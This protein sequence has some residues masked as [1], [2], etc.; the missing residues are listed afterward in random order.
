MPELEELMRRLYLLALLCCTA[1]GTTG[2]AP[3]NTGPRE[4]TVSNGATD[5]RIT[6]EDYT[7]GTEFAT[8]RDRVW[9][10]LL[11]VHEELGIPL[12]NADPRAGTLSYF[13]QVYDH[14]IA[15][16]PASMYVDCG[17]GSTGPR[18][19]SYRIRLIINEAVIQPLGNEK[20]SLHTT[21]QVSAHATNVSGSELDC[22]STGQLE[23]RI[24]KLV[25]ERLAS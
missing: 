13:K 16:K 8:S 4:Q 18:A 19:D 15:G 17:S 21:L 1:C 3:G 2:A 20:T 5:V 9:K 24:A 11:A 25:A 7:Q 14:S 23:Q 10:A 22:S 6:H 12:A